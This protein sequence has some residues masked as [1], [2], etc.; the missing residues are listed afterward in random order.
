[1]IQLFKKLFQ[2][3]PKFLTDSKFRI[4]EAFEI[5]GVKYYQFD[6]PFNTPCTRALA[7]IKYYEEMRM[8]CTLE[9]L[10]AWTDAQANIL[11]KA[12]EDMTVPK[13]NRL[14]LTG[15]FEKIK[16]LESMNARLKERMNLAMDLDLVYKLASVVFFDGT[17]NPNVYEQRH[18]FEKIERWKKAEGAADFFLRQPIKKLVPFLDGQEQH[19]QIYQEIVEAVKKED[20]KQ[21]SENLSSKQKMI[22]TKPLS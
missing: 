21:V 19:I 8:K 16:E 20:W 4:V 7:A 18:G 15:M 22:Y 10:T 5:D 1:M 2:R 14:N 11:A 9:Y 13:H 17:E 6:D 12:K 3:E